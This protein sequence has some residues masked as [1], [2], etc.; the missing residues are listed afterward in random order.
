[1]ANAQNKIA[2]TSDGFWLKNLVD[3]IAGITKGW[4]D[5]AGVDVDP[6]PNHVQFGT[7]EL[8]F[9]NNGGGYE[10]LLGGGAIQ[11][12]NQTSNPRSFTVEVSHRGDT[13][14]SI[15]R[16]SKTTDSEHDVY[17]AETVD[18]VGPTLTLKVD[19]RSGESQY[20]TKKPGWIESLAAGFGKALGPKLALAGVMV[21][22]GLVFALFGQSLVPFL[23]V[24]GGSV[25]AISLFASVL[26]R[27]DKLP[28]PDLL[29]GSDN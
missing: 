5:V 23:W 16:L 14:E 7:R 9:K 12:E 3:S 22:P 27:N 20:V 26:V 17:S 25:A 10:L 28:H 13:G 8:K 15:T 18:D 2:D 29:P 6:R 4:D 19:R 21:A 11:F 1:M 24:A